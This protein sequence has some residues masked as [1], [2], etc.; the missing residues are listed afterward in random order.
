[1]DSQHVKVS[2]TRHKSALHLSIFFIFFDHSE[3]KSAPK[4]PF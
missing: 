3:S 1:M 2:E 4:T